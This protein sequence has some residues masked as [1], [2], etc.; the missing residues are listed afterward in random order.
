[1]RVFAVDCETWRIEPGCL[2]P[3]LVCVSW[4]ERQSDGLLTSG[5]LDRDAGLKL[6]RV[7]LE[8]VAHREVILVMQ[9]GVYDLG[10]AAAADDSLLELIFNAYEVGGIRDTKERQKLIDL[11]DGDMKFTRD[12]NGDFI[13]QVYSLDALARRFTG[14][15]LDKSADSWRLRYKELDG[16]PLEDWPIEAKRY[17][18][19]DAEA[20]LEVYEKQQLIVSP[21]CECIDG[22]H[23][24]RNEAEQ[25][26]AHWALHLQS[27]WGIR[28]DAEAVARLRTEVE[29]D[30][31]RC[32]KGVLALEAEQGIPQNDEWSLYKFHTFQRGVRAGTTEITRRTSAIQHRVKAGFEAQGL[33]PP[34]TDG[35]RQAE[36]QGEDITLKHVAT[37]AEAMRDSKDPVLALMAEAQYASKLKATYIPAL[38]SG[39]KNAINVGYNLLLES[40]RTSVQ[41]TFNPQVLPRRDG[42]R[43]CVVPR[44]GYYL[45]S[46]DYDQ[47]E[48]CTL[49][50]V[51]YDLLQRS[52]IRDA[53][54]AGRD[55]HVQFA[56]YWL[57][58][59]YEEAL[60]R[61]KRAKKGEIDDPEILNR[62]QLA[63]VPNFGKPGGMGDTALIDFA[64]STYGIILQI[65]EARE[66]SSVY[67]EAHPDMVDFFE[68][69]A[70]HLGPLG[71][72][73]IEQLRSG[74]IRG[75][76]TFCQACNTLFQGLAADGA[77]LA[78]WRVARECY[79][80][81]MYASDGRYHPPTRERSPLF[82]TRPIAFIH[83][84]ILAEVPI[85]TAHEAAFR[86]SQVMNEAMREYVPDV[87]ISSTPALMERWHKGATDVYDDKGRLIPWRP[88]TKPTTQLKE[89]A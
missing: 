8:M 13:K 77:K 15:T 56:A 79:E 29:A 57:Q 50:Q 55:L 59:P 21:V 43:E 61:Y 25:L 74:R 88:K 14:R 27:I 2:T 19:L 67:F 64:K 39:A 35:G 49:G 66:L 89:A 37:S 22:L 72:G 52:T 70:E 30:L 17:P 86:L 51:L 83:D 63:K 34:L 26:R 33:N 44:P 1:M 36:A 46:V 78:L 24:V 75:G 71:E 7:L 69:V 10:V 45:C 32:F 85:A 81:G 60:S 6:F 28:I 12:E 68:W 76:C 4:A 38:E 11:A 65:D 5:L 73:A 42:V 87:K 82:G 31:E 62:R 84:E 16:V 48:L 40:G 80:G 53:I 18:I 23:S 41:G 54:N 9:N 3:R 58:I 47:L 20:T